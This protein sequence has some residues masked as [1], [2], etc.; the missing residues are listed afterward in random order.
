MTECVYE[1][2]AMAAV[3]EFGCC[4]H[5]HW[6]VRAEIALGWRMLADYLR[7]WADYEAWCEQNGVA[8]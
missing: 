8:A 5:H 6:I 7:A 2:C 1:D 3:D 4:G